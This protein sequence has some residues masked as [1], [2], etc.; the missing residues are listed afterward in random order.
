MRIQTVI[1][2]WAGT[3]ID[4]GCRAPVEAYRTVFADLGADLS[5]AQVRA[6]MGLPKRDHIVRLLRLPESVDAFARRGAS[7][8][9]ADIDRIYADVTEAMVRACAEC[10]DAIPGASETL[11]WLRAHGV[12]IGGTTGYPRRV[13]EAV[14]PIARRQGVELDVLVCADEAPN[15]RPGPG[16]LLACLKRLGAADVAMCVKV[17]D[18]PP[19]IAEGVAAGAWTVGV[20]ATGN[21]SDFSGSDPL[22][23]RT[24]PSVADLP[25]L[26]ESWP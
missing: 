18:T 20:T 19:G 16:Q 1:F 26:L 14:L 21:V 11:A 15:P 4:A 5:E 2:D 3:L 12:R 22:P 25:A 24:C 7:A 10:A 17:D 8:T 6:D 13:M 9:E 23:D